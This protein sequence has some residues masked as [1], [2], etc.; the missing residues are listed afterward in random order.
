M[1]NIKKLVA[2]IFLV[3]LVLVYFFW[4]LPYDS[5]MPFDDTEGKALAIGMCISLLLAILFG[6]ISS[7]TKD[8]I[9]YKA[10]LLFGLCFGSF[11]VIW[12]CWIFGEKNRFAAQPVVKTDAIIT[13]SLSGRFSINIHYQYQDSDGHRQNGEDEVD[14][15]LPNLLYITS[16]TKGRKIPVNYLKASPQV[17]RMVEDHYLQVWFVKA[18]LIVLGCGMMCSSGAT[19][20]KKQKPPDIFLH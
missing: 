10:I 7:Y 12:G 20:I 6:C 1:G 2:G 18:I 4:I 15:I 14:N 5:I 19:L 8:L 3:S 17:S 16:Y 9:S 13:E 11:L